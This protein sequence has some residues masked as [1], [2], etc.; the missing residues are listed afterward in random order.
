VLKV[1]DYHKHADEC[2]KLAGLSSLPDIREQLLKLAESW[3][4]LAEQRKQEIA[5]G[6][7]RAI[8]ASGSRGN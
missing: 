8:S 7:V 3:D 4:Q 5:R 2:R 6:K 1:S